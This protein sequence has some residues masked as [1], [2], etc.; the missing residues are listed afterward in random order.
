MK[1]VCSKIFCFL[2]TGV[3]VGVGVVVSDP[4]I[5]SESGNSLVSFFE[6]VGTVS[7]QSLPC[8]PLYSESRL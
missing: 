3:G 7:L 5:G 6:V 4:S 8:S 1:S 2:G